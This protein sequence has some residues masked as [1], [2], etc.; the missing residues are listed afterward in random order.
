MFYPFARM[1]LL[2]KK[3]NP[4]WDYQLDIPALFLGG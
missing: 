3:V 1:W 4:L 2:R